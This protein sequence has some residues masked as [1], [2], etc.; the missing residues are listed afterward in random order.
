MGKGKKLALP[1]SVLKKVLTEGDIWAKLSIVVMGAANLKRK[2]LFK[3][4]LFLFI[5]VAFLMY[6]VKTGVAAL[7]G[8][9]TLGTQTQGWV[10]DEA[11]GIDVLAAGDNSMLMLLWGVLCLFVIVAFVI[12]W[13]ANMKSA[14]EVQEIEASGKKI[15]KLID[16]VKTYLDTKFNRTMLALPMLGVLAF[17]VLPL[18]Y[19]IL[20][21]FTN[22]DNTHQPPGNLFDWVGLD[23]FFTVLG[24]GGLISQTF[25][26]VL[27]WTLVWAVFATFLNY[28]AGIMLALLINRKGVKFK[29][30]W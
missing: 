20:V 7:Q 15:P 25:W 16:D 10:F 30:F 13:R 6:M 18:V 8:M 29:G 24:S 27:G 12:T 26:P 22:Y 11:L 4:I 17:N 28:I 19:M 1:E 5:E 21:A 14:L 3:G 2:Q 23:N 9:V